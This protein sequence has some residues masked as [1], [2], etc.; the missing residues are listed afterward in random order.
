VIVNTRGG[1]MICNLNISTGGCLWNVMLLLSFCMHCFAVSCNWRCC[2]GMTI[3][4]MSF[5]RW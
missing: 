4:H 1:G 2:H 5:C 3:W